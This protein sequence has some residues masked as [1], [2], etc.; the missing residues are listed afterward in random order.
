ME[1]Q[2]YVDDLE[3]EIAGA[4]PQYKKNTATVS[5]RPFGSFIDRSNKVPATNIKRMYL[6]LSNIWYIDS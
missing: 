4:P 2:N 1:L 5:L 6:F 3:S